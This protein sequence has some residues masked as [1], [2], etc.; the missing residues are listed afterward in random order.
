M[1]VVGSRASCWI[2]HF[3][4]AFAVAGPPGTS[5]WCIGHWAGG[6]EEEEE[7]MCGWSDGI[8]VAAVWSTGT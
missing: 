6:R 4:G 2:G 5:A 7:G 8:E 1:W 3:A